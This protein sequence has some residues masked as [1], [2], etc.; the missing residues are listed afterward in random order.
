MEERIDFLL[1]LFWSI[2]SIVDG[3]IYDH[4]IVV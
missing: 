3:A 1:L 4:H 2:L